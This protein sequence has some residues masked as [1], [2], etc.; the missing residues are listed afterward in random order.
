MNTRARRRSNSSH[1]QT[2]VSTTTPNSHLFTLSISTDVLPL[3]QHASFSA[4]ESSRPIWADL[5]F[6]IET[7]QRAA[8]QRASFHSRS[9]CIRGSVNRSDTT[10]ENV[11]TPTDNLARQK[12]SLQLERGG[13]TAPVK[14]IDPF[15]HA[16]FKEMG[17]DP[18]WIQ[19][20][21]VSPLK[22]QMWA[23]W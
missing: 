6:K 17:L 12:P 20:I 21:P 3:T 1:T 2:S 8:S 22:E 11:N 10:P 4:A 19:I 16:G 23:P 7:P 5:G 13:A 18:S 9:A 14:R 15:I